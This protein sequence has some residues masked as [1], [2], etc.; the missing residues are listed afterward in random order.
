MVIEKLVVPVAKGERVPSAHCTCSGV[1]KASPGAVTDAAWFG[2]ESV[3]IA[4]K[5]GSEESFE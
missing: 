1:M 3:R 2:R 4:F 5:A